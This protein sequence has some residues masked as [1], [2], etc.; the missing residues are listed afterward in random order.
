[1][2]VQRCCRTQLFQTF[3]ILAG[4]NSGMTSVVTIPN[5]RASNVTNSSQF[6]KNSSSGT[7]AN[8]NSSLTMRQMTLTAM[9]GYSFCAPYDGGSVNDPA[10]NPP[11]N[12]NYQPVPHAPIFF[13]LPQASDPAFQIDPITG[14]ITG[15]PNMPGQYAMGICVEEHRDGVYLGRVLRDFQFNVVMCDVKLIG[16]YTAA[17]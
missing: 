7:C 14:F 13:R 10:P 4:H 1:M 16:R 11:S 15:T 17:A 8:S 12:P 6:F 3:R 2:V 9:S 5:N